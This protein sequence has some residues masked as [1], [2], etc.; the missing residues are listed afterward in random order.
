MIILNL[1]NNQLVHIKGC[2]RAA[3]VWKTICNIHQTKNLSNIF[4]IRY[5]LFKWKMEEGNNFLDHI[6]NIKVLVDQFVC[7]DVP[8]KE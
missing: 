8:V 7:L 6:N 5:K 3:E 1:T 2:K 4:F